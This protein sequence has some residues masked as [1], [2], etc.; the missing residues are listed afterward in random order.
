MVIDKVGIIGE[1]VGMS[2]IFDDASGACIPCTVIW[3][4]GCNITQIKTLKKD[5]YNAIQLSYGSKKKKNI[6]KSVLGHL[7]KVKVDSSLLLKE[8]RDFDFTKIPVCEKKNATPDSD[9][10]TNNGV[11]TNDKTQND[12]QNVSEESTKTDTENSS[13]CDRLNSFL[14]R[15][16]NISDLFFEGDLITVVGKSKGKG[17]QGVVKR[18]RFSG[19]GGQTHGQHNRL[20][21]P[22][23]VGASSFPSRVFKGTRMGGKTGNSRVTVKN[24]RVLKVINNENLIVIKGS[25]PGDTGSIVI[26]KK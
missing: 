24:L 20:R 2:S 4:E 25:V 10:A 17:F 14:G 16:I 8:I 1:K 3:S 6:S 11:T 13:G 15:K 19:V 23:S 21:A 7:S 5:G 18:H 26:L 22:G 12:T 9:P